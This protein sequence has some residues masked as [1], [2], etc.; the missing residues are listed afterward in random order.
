[1]GSLTALNHYLKPAFDEDGWD[2]ELNTMIDRLDEQVANVK[3]PAF[4]AKGDGVTDDQAAIQAAIDSGAGVVFFPAGNYF[5]GSGKTLTLRANQVIQGVGKQ[6]T[7]ITA[8]NAYVF[9]TPA[10]GSLDR[11]FIND[12]T[13]ALR[14]GSTTGGAL[15][16][17]SDSYHSGWLVSRCTFVGVSGCS[18]SVVHVDGWI[19]SDFAF[20]DFLSGGGH[21]LAVTSAGFVSNIYT[22][23]RCRAQTYNTPDLTSYAGFYFE[24]SS[25][26]VTACVTESIKGY[27][28]WFKDVT[29]GRVEGHWFEDNYNH[30]VRIDDGSGITLIHNKFHYNDAA[31]DAAAR[32]IKVT[33]SNVNSRNFH[34]IIGNTFQDGSNSGIAVDLDAN[35]THCVVMFNRG[36]RSDTA[37]LTWGNANNTIIC[38]DVTTNVVDVSYF[39]S[40]VN[41]GKASASTNWATHNFGAFLLYRGTASQ[42]F[43]RARLAQLVVDSDGSH[44]GVAMGHANASTDITKEG[45]AIAVGTNDRKLKLA[46]GDGTNLKTVMQF[47]DTSILINNPL[48]GGGAMPINFGSG[49]VKFNQNA[50]PMS[51]YGATAISKPTV[52][53]SRGGNAALAS[54]L[55]ALA[56][57]GLITDSSSA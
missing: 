43:D 37:S 34:Q 44:M 10:T 17:V 41:V 47:T 8:S 24:G 39:P 29:Y 56:N 6:K 48:T 52:T 45:A 11:V 31:G 57:L 20:C 30:N 28:I 13:A 22:V 1:M 42:T 14:A 25:P 51:F 21:Q 19:G 3:A 35:T 4:G 36:I 7:N 46:V 38:N 26:E 9:T 15:K 5:L 18:D 54:L 2:D 53:G 50:Q 23:H 27:G 33:T 40:N 16:V 32:H 49:G 12:L 55:T